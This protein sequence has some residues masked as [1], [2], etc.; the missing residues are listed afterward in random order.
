ML[1]KKLV[2]GSLVGA[3]LLAGVAIL[4]PTAAEAAVKGT[5][6]NCHTMH[7]MQDGATVTT[8]TTEQLLNQDCVGCHTGNSNNA[9]G[10]D[11][12][13]PNAPQVGNAANATWNAAGYFATGTSAGVHN[14]RDS[15]SG[16]TSDVN[17][18]V[19]PGGSFDAGVGGTSF[20]CDDCHGATGA[21]HG[22][23][24]S[25]RMLRADANNDGTPDGSTVTPETNDTQYG[26]KDATGATYN[27]PTMNQFCADCHG[28]FHG[29]T[30]TGSPSPFTRHPTTNS[31]TA[32]D[33]NAKYSF[34]G[35]ANV[36]V[37]TSNGVMCISCHRA[38]GGAYDDLLRFNYAQQN[39]G[40][41][42]GANVG[43]EGC[44]GNK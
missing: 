13:A 7:N 17:L 5:C 16:L 28:G 10:I 21:H 38:H 44:H 4:V 39:A 11:A 3:T 20:G 33:A 29:D 32:V 40:S 30:L 31:T 35:T 27:G 6:V 2:L 24:A 18:S 23:P 41:T 12:A 36:P 26:N 43:C 34:T 19:A 15:I 14:V 1:N 22:T 25:F 42:Q 9:N 37:G 8:A